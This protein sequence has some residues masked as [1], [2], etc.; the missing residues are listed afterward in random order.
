[1]VGV[2]VG[3]ETIPEPWGSNRKAQPPL[4]VKR[5]WGTEMS[6]CEEDLSNLGAEYGISISL[7]YC[8]AN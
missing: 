7:M 6:C 8:G 2:N 4:V 1:M 5:E 3:R